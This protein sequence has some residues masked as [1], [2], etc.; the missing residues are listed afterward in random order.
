MTDADLDFNVDD[1]SS[2]FYSQEKQLKKL[3][4]DYIMSKIIEKYPD[5][6]ENRKEQMLKQVL[7]VFVNDNKHVNEILDYFDIDIFELFKVIY[8]KYSFIFSTCYTNKIHD[9]IKYKK[10]VHRKR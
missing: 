1:Y 2:S 9:I 4:D 8:R 6:T 5:F 10:Y 7:V 3:D